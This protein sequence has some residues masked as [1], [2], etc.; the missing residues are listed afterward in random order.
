MHTPSWDMFLV[1]IC[2]HEELTLINEGLTRVIAI[3]IRTMCNGYACEMC[4]NNVTSKNILLVLYITIIIHP[5]ED[6][7]NVKCHVKVMR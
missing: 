4:W 5:L 3:N 7:I 6:V 1:G 2:K